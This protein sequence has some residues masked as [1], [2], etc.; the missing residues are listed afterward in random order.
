MNNFYLVI[1]TTDLTTY[2]YKNKAQ[3]TITCQGKLTTKT[4]GTTIHALGVTE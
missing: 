4:N 2:H 3:K 1:E